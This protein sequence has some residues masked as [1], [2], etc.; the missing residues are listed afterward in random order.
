QATCNP[1]TDSASQKLINPGPGLTGWNGTVGNNSTTPGVN[2]GPGGL[3]TGITLLG[4]SGPAVAADLRKYLNTSGQALHPET[5]TT[6]VI[7]FDYAPTTNFLRGLDV[8]GTWYQVKI[9]GALQGFTNPNTKFFADP[10]LGFAIIVPTD[11]AKR[12]IDVAGCS[13]NNTP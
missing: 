13:N 4:S 9:N 12:G 10:G 3:P 8:Q 11:L 2:C 5:A 7:G 1:L 6:W